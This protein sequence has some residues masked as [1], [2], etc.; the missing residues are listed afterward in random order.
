MSEPPPGQKPRPEPGPG[1]YAGLGVQLVASILIFVWIG[2]W[3][4]RKLNT[5]G[6]LTVLGVFIGFGATMYSLMRSLK[7]DQ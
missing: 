4:D 3:A 2:Q 5:G 1:K 6:L 7:R